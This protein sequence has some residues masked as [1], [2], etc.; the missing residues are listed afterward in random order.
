MIVR[1]ALAWWAG[2]LAILGGCTTFGMGMPCMG[3]FAPP[4]HP[5][6]RFTNAQ[7]QV[8]AKL[9]PT[10]RIKVLAYTNQPV[11]DGEM[12]V[13]VAPWDRK[14][15]GREASLHDDGLNG[16]V[17]AGDGEWY[18]ELDWGYYTAG[19]YEMY[20]MLH[21]KPGNRQPAY[22]PLFFQMPHVQYSGATS[23]SEPD[24]GAEGEGQ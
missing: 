2:L 11:K 13:V 16:D 1:K 18:G 9:S 12:A 8:P 5:T 23:N 10:T 7:A 17:R 14:G 3:A 24:S 22:M 15:Q 20:V 4:Q 6:A 19:T 21:F